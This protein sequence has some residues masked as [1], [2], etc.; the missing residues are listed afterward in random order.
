MDNKNEIKQQLRTF[1]ARFMG[2]RELLD[3]EDIFALGIL[4]SLFAMQLV[5]FVEKEFSIKVEDED[6]DVDNFKSV[7]AIADLVE[8]KTAGVVAD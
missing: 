1:L 6:L 2:N 7:N 8:R 4:N 3:D 5:A